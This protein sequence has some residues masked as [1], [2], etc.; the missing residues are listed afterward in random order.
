TWRIAPDLH[1]AEEQPHRSDGGATL[2]PENMLLP[3][4]A[5]GFQNASGTASRASLPGVSLSLERASM[6]SPRMVMV[7]R[8][9]GPETNGPH[10]ELT[11]LDAGF[12]ADPDLGS[13]RP[14]VL[15]DPPGLVM[16]HVELGQAG[17][18]L[19]LT[20]VDAKGNRGWSRNLGMEEARGARLLP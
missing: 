15:D 11:Y 9:N 2:H 6:S 16:A 14:V 7:L 1:A 20:R 8:Q 12:L 19:V 18:E 5:A 4:H 17:R 13:L 3:R 10:P